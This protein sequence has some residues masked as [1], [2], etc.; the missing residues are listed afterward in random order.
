MKPS[1]NYSTITAIIL[2]SGKGIRF[3]KPKAEAEVDGV[4]FTSAITSILQKAGLEY[5]HV[6]S[7]YPTGEMLETLKMAIKKLSDTGKTTA[8]TGFLCFPVDF[9]FVSVKTISKLAEAHLAKPE[10]I[11]RPSY[12]GYS[13]HPIIIPAN[14]N[15]GSDDDGN[16]LRGVILHS[17]LPIHDIQVEDEG[18]HMNINTRED[19]YQWTAKN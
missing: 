19:L 16:G 7:G 13:G 4:N 14:L 12:Q 1:T 8:C 10:A 6:A 2:A 18:I 17:K 9:P 11:I 5:I 3:G 15:L